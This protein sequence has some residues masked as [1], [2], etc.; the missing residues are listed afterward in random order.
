MI[1][2]S[3]LNDLTTSRTLAY[4]AAMEEPASTPSRE[5]WRLLL[6]M[7]LSKE[8]HDRF[9]AA[10]AAAGTPH[11]GALKALMGL[12]EGRP[13]SMR[14]LADGL[15]CDASYITSLVDDLEALGYVERRI[16]PTDRRVKL[17]HLTP[18]GE[19]ARQ[20]ALALLHTPPAAFERLSAR[21]AT[22]LARLLS[23]V[24]AAPAPG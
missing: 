17:V 7:F 22:T 5:A 14:T 15:H 10:C 1:L 12:D 16:S 6:T 3:K 9:H 21:E 20:H 2:L 4:H 11:P 13:Q 24:S 18:D 8:S 23:K 19:T